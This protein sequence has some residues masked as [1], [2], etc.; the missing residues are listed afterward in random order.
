MRILALA[1]WHHF[2]WM[3]IS[4]AMLGLG[5]SGTVLFLVR[6]QLLRAYRVVVPLLLLATAVSIGGS[7]VLF[8]RIG[9]FDA[10]LLFFELRQTG[11]LVLTYLVYALPF[12][13]AGLAINLIFLRALQ[14]IGTLY[15]ANLLGSAGG[16]VLI[17]GALHAV[18]LEY[19]PGLL[20]LLPLLGALLLVPRPVPRLLIAA[21]LASVLVV[22][23]S[24]IDPVLPG[25]SQYK[26][27]SAALDLPDAEVKFRT[28]SPEGQL[29]IVSAPALR[30]APGLSLHY[31]EAPPVRDVIFYDG[32]YFGTFL[33]QPETDGSILD[34]TTR[35]LPYTVRRP[36]SVAVLNAAAGEDVAH[37]LANDASLVAAQEN[38]G[39]AR[40]LLTASAGP[41]KGGPFTNPA[42][43]INRYS[44]RRFLATTP[45]DTFDLVVVPVIGAFGGTAGVD[46]LDQH[47]HL[48]REAFAEMYRVLSPDG[49]IAVT[50]WLEDPPRPSLRLLATMRDLLRDHGVDDP[51]SRIAAIR[52]WGGATFLLSRSP[53]TVED[54]DRIRSSAEELGFDPLLLPDLREGERDRF[55]MPMDT[56]Y[57]SQVDR[58]LAGEASPER[59]QPSSRWFDDQPVSDARPFFQHYLR[60]GALVE[61]REVFGLRALPYLE[62]GFFLAGAAA[63]QAVVAAFLLI[64]LPLAVSGWKQGGRRWTFLYFAGT[65]AGFMLYEIALIQAMTL[66][67]GHPVYAAASVLGTLLVS[68]GL[69]SFVTRSRPI[70]ESAPRK[71]A[72]VV[73]LVLTLFALVLPPMVSRTLGSPLL[74]RSMITLVASVVPGFF[75]GMLFPLGLRNLSRSREEHVP[76]ACAIDSCLAVSVTAPATLIALQAGLSAIIALAALAYVPVLL[77]SR[78]LS[79]RCG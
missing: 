42:V 79:T 54:S 55:N 35:V 60:A 13:F 77:A 9:T 21:V 59:A 18:P 53:L 1:Q 25:P 3:V 12:F 26:E 4:L 17:V 51:R 39:T 31:R 49:M 36:R 2:A 45:D 76:W 27:I 47:F 41:L 40:R 38:H 69:G 72:S 7:T 10:F 56:S 16:A 75:M 6:R 15:F 48:T 19:L 29:E 46:S 67:L 50:V 22:G 63:V 44:T 5:A 11:L 33:E 28:S 37:A 32:E 66:Y 73:I 23:F 8:G 57:F 61:L 62:L 20:A 78:F 68:T 70:G 64:V 24:L 65:G 58:V 74:L 43:R 71:A 34:Q 52:S 30:Y 14:Q